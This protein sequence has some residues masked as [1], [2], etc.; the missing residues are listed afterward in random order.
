MISFIQSAV[1]IGMILLFGCIGEII[2]EKAGHLNL[3]I[4]GIMCMGTAGGC[5]GVEVYMNSL[6]NAQDASWL[7]IIL[8]SILCA[9]LLGA[10]GGA[11][12]SFL[13]VTLKSNQNITGL[14]LT[15]FGAGVAQFIMDNYV[16][17]SRFAQASIVFRKCLPFADNLGVFGEV[18]LSY[19]FFVYLAI[20]LA[21]VTTIVL[22]KTRVGLNLRAIG[23][24][25]SA[26]D[27]EGINVSLYKYMAILI[28]SAIAGLGGMVYIMDFIGGSWENASTI[29]SFG[30]LAI[31]LVIFMLWKPDL[32]IIGSI[33]FGGFFIV[34]N[35]ITGI[36]FGQARL[37][38]LSPYVITVIVLII[39]SITNKK[40][41]QPPLSLGI[42]YFR[43]ER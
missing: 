12:Y 28:G 8:I 25:P 26:A 23:E 17:R 40:E 21:I 11:I 41:N 24:N 27:A 43:E 6:T 5:W 35:Y 1:V 15:T 10:F 19:G 36:S 13:T 16:T 18:F 29:Q 22:K 31:A 14:A 4:P 42:N 37:L 39:T 2:T 34:T 32:S 20:A 30:W 3:G 38:K 9:S 7:A 33:I